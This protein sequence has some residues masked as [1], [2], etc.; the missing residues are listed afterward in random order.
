M[1]SETSGVM[2]ETDLCNVYLAQSHILGRIET[3]E[4]EARKTKTKI[5]SKQV[6]SDNLLYIYFDINHL[7]ENESDERTQKGSMV[8]L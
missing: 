4:N 5:T 1:S 7:T 3:V 2:V 6:H 8:Q